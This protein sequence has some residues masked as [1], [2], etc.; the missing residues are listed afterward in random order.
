MDPET[1][2]EIVEIKKD[3]RELRNSQDAEIQHDREKYIKLLEEGINNDP[4]TAQILL[5]VDGFRSKKDIE[6]ETKIPN[7]TCWRKLDRLMSKEVIFPLE[8]SKNSSP[9]YQQSRWFKK[10]RLEDYV[11]NKYHK[12]IS[13]EDKKQEENVTINS[14]TEQNQN[15]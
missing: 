4:K 13:T 1:H 14:T 11:K 8:E 6:T 9:I 5:L 15:I 10:L 2:K 7:A 12:Q 3:I